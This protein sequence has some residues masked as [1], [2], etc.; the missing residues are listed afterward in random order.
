ML[1]SRH[2]KKVVD[3]YRQLCR[4]LVNELEGLPLAIRVA[5]RLLASE[6]KYHWGVEQ[7]LSELKEDTE[8]IVNSE[9]PSDMVDISK[10]TTPKVAA[11][12]KKST[13]KLEE[14]IREYFAMLGSFAPKPAIFDLDAMAYIWQVEDPRPIVRDLVLRGLLEPVEAKKFQM[15]ALLVTHAKS[16]L[17][18]NDN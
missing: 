5:G 17:R 10:E 7:L 8:I 1:L 18:M 11:L 9:A 6:M 14:H 16:L 13:D 15:H 4:D 3:M 2:A 12:L